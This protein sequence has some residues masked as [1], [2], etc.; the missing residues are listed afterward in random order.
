MCPVQST[1]AAEV[2]L[3]EYI[4]NLFS[5]SFLGAWSCHVQLRQN[6]D[7]Y[8]K[9]SEYSSLYTGVKPVKSGKF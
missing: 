5:I 2:R 1:G 9:I 6:D 3:K 4:K 8:L 7:G